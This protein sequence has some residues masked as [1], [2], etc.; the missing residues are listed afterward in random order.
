[1]EKNEL[2]CV[3]FISWRALGSRVG[4]L[5]RRPESGSLGTWRGST[6]VVTEE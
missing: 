6:G 4:R 5:A 2:A 3:W 1:M